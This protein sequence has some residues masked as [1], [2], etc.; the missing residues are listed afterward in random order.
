MTI[1]RAAAGLS[2]AVSAILV[3]GLGS[4]SAQV[5]F[6][7]QDDFAPSKTQQGTNIT[8]GPPGVVGDSD[9]STTNGLGN[10][11]NAG[12]TG[13]AGALPLV[14]NVTGYNQTQIGPDEA[15]NQPFLNAMAA[16]NT[17][18]LDYY[19]PQA[20]TLGATGSNYFQLVPVFNWSGGYQQL[21][22][23][24]A[25]NAAGL[26][27]G[28]HTVTYDYSS[29]VASLQSVLTTKPSYF[30]LFLVANTGGVQG[31]GTTPETGT[32]IVDNFRVSGVPEP[33]SL[34][35]L[36]L[37]GLGLLGVARRRIRR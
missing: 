16:H 6:T 13:T 27:A 33:A 4:A 30:Q 25:F 18:T 1:Q 31:D 23:N 8:V 14:Q 32:V 2:L 34:A 5:L 22:N 17:L 37:G 7:T 19:L 21:F 3:W 28:E 11:T 36:S 26:T 12:G 10:T 15:G 9:G 29:F 20:I 24:G 35:L